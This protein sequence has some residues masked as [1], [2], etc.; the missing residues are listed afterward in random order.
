M[1]PT[2]GGRPMRDLTIEAA[3]PVGTKCAVRTAGGSYHFVVAD[4][5]ARNGLFRVQGTHM[6]CT[7][8]LELKEVE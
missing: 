5:S 2:I 1:I 3:P 7:H 4:D 6:K 8:W